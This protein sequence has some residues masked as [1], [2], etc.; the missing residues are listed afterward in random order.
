MK[1]KHLIILIV[2]ILLLS[3]VWLFLK[4][5]P[6]QKIVQPQKPTFVADPPIMEFVPGAP[7]NIRFSVAS[8]AIIRPPSLHQSFAVLPLDP[9]PLAYTLATKLG[10]TKPSSVSHGSTQK[11]VWK[12]ATNSLSFTKNGRVGAISFQSDSG[13]QTAQGS[14]QSAAEEYLRLV[15]GAG[16]KSYTLFS[17]QVITDSLYEGGPEIKGGVTLFLFSYSFNNTPVLLSNLDIVSASVIA[18]NDGKIFSSSITLPPGTFTLRSNHTPL[19]TE[20]I[21]ASLNANKGVLVSSYDN[22]N[23]EYGAEP[24]FSAVSI[25]R[26]TSVLYYETGSSLLVPGFLMDGAGESGNKTQAVQYFIRATE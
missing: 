7:K 15:M 16:A 25:S 21:I 3:G 6:P 1:K 4:K 22:P 11:T 12:S 10:F 23:D 8:G 14:P 9:E 5:D 18:G 17:Q 26:S 19:S 2:G 24:V 20:N 13:Y